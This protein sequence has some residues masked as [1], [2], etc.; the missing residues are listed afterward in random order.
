MSLPPPLLPAPRWALISTP[1]SPNNP[2]T[3]RPSTLQPPMVPHPTANP[4]STALPPP[5]RLTVAPLP[6]VNMATKVHKSCLNAMNV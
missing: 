3:P 4:L 1:S 6:Q 5:S 2:P